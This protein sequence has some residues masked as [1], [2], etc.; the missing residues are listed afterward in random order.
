MNPIKVCYNCIHYIDEPREKNT[1]CL[2]IEQYVSRY[3]EPCDK[4]KEPTY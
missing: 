4:F 1:L 3:D 2:V